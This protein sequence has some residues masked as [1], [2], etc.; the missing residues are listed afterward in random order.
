MRFATSSKLPRARL[1]YFTQG[2]K[3]NRRALV[4]IPPGG[5]SDLGRADAV[6]SIMQYRYTHSMFDKEQ[7]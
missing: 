4:S 7:L 5:R 1:A 3:L 6:R 2:R